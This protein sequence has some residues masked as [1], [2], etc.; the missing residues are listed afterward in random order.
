MSN[1]NIVVVG[2]S[3]GG[4]DALQQLV[5][6]L[7]ADLPAAIFVVLHVGEQ[8][9]SMLHNI[10]SRAGALPA[11]PAKDGEAI[12]AG[13]IYV[14]VPGRHLLVENKVRVVSGPKE[15]R[16]RPAIDPLFRSAA[17]AHGDRVIGVV[18]TGSL[19]DGAAGTVAIKRCGGMVIVQDPED[20]FC[21]SMPRSAIRIDDPDYI[22]PLSEIGPLINRLARESLSKTGTA[23]PQQI[24][25]EAKISAMDKKAMEEEERPGM[26]SRF[27]CPECHG[28]LWE[29]QEG[30]LLR[31]RCRTGHAYTAAHLEVEH[32]VSVEGALWAAFRALEE[33]ASLSL[34]MAKRA[35][36]HKNS[37]L[38]HIY[39]ERALDK[40]QNA[41]ALR[42]LLMEHKTFV[43]EVS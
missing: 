10:L 25:T 39:E 37:K 11:V 34:R 16:H 23:P 24:S 28:V 42:Q 40:K 30:E 26:P 29:I 31:F 13:K 32:N 2:A 1:R 18:L 3:L 14:A 7:D 4:V 21:S 33:S 36:E 9:P 38:A 20:A 5:A 12:E 19:D 8:S 22:V 35:Q 6:S 15:N 27:A 41:E 17:A 43:E